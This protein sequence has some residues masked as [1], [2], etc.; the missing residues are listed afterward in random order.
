MET[1]EISGLKVNP[2]NPRGEV[3]VDDSLREL[4]DS[5]KE[6]GVLQPILITPDGTIVCGHRRVK[7]CELAG[8]LTVPCLVRDLSEQQRLHVMLIE[9][10]QREDLT[11][12]QTAKAY[13]L[14]IDHGLT[15]TQI[16]KATGFRSETVSRHLDILTLHPDLHNAFDGDQCLPLGCIPYLRDLP[17]EKQLVI[18]TRAKDKGWTVSRIARE[19]TNGNGTATQSSNPQSASK[20]DK[21]IM[22]RIYERIDNG[23]FTP[24]TISKC[25]E[26]GS[27]VFPSLSPAD[28][29]EYLN[30]L[31]RQG[32]CRWTP[33]GG[34]KDNQ[35]GQSTMLCMP[36]I[37]EIG[38]FSNATN[39]F[40]RQPKERV[41]A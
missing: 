41:R 6:Q 39:A 1:R 25:D 30:E 2:N 36:A 31:V 37:N 40:Q 12:L 17:L 3:V 11:A 18:G 21:S 27:N 8:V 23:C 22:D 10:L 35:R 4:A 38:S 16:A 14:L 7:A 32:R 29:K 34:K 20:L 33:Q 26:C 9:N 5:I 19:C 24:E 13:Q 28:I 15:I